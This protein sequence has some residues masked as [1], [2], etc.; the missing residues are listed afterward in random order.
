M[1]DKKATN[2][3]QALRVRAIAKLLIRNHGRAHILQHAATKWGLADRAADELIAR[4]TAE[5]LEA[6]RPSIQMTIARVATTQWEILRAAMRKKEYFLARQIL[7]DIAKLGGLEQQTINHIIDD[8]REFSSLT[9]AELD[10][11]LEQ[12]RLQ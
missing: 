8:K 2:A 1:S 4:A 9:D 11:K 6:N 10:A 5:I 7:M 3:E 12:A